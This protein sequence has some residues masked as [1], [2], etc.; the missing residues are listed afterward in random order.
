MPQNLALAWAEEQPEDA[1][2]TRLATYGTFVPGG[3]NHAV[4]APLEG[5]WRRGWLE[6]ETRTARAGRW[7][8]YSGFVPLPGGP[9]LAAWLFESATLA[10]AWDDL[11][12]FEGPAFLRR[13]VPFFLDAA[14]VV[15][16]QVYT[17]EDGI[18]VGA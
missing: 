4:L 15:T 10:Y 13:G 17:L 3:E 8:G 6:G 12:A 1:A 18:E 16:A 7:A 9:R 11:D 14:T 2:L 5:T